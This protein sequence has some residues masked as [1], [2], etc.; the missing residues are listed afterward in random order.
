MIRFFLFIGFSL[1]L[2]A[3]AA[4]PHGLTLDQWIQQQTADS[5]HSMLAN[6]SPADGIPG[7]VIASPENDAIPYYFHWVRDAALTNLTLLHLLEMT[8]GPEQDGYKQKLFDFA[9]FSA[10][11]QTTAG[12]GEPK[13]YVTGQPYTG[14]WARPQNDGP[15]LRAI[16]LMQFMN[17]L[18]AHQEGDSARKTVVPVIQKDLLYVRDHWRDPSYDLWEEVK[19]DHFY[20]RMVQRRALL[21]GARMAGPLGLDGPQLAAQANLMSNEILK[22]WDATRGY[23]VA[24]LNWTDGLDYKASNLDASFVLGILHGHTDDGFLPYTDSRVLQTVQKV[25]DAFKPLYGVNAFAG[26][27]GVAIGRYVEDRYAGENF[28]GGNPWVLLTAAMS[29]YLNRAALEFRMSGNSRSARQYKDLADEMILRVKYHAPADGIFSE[30]ID[31]N[32]GF[33]TSARDLTWS[34]TEVLEALAARAADGLR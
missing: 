11:I 33:M 6:M 22:H 26:V 20:T 1:A 34:H 32:T 14:P 10:L 4:D 27:P 21:E 8:G 9:S 16:T 5:I 28:N 2:N 12:L 24:T 31:R 25:I 17:W 19:G 7:S 29:Q 18:I 23:F 3:H 15:A 30:Q 13:F